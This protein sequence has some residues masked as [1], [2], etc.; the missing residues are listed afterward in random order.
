M[1]LC[2]FIF[3]GYHASVVTINHVTP[4]HEACLSGHVACVR[5][6][7]KAGANV[8]ILPLIIA[9]IIAI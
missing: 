9:I 8:N 3:Q 7:I 6:L 2:A 1:I 4:L 5:A